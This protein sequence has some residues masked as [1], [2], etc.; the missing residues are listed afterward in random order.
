MWDNLIAMALQLLVAGVSFCVGKFLLP[1]LPKDTAAVI[2]NKMDLVITYADQYVN[3]ADRFMEGSSGTEKLN[4]VVGQLKEVANRYGFQASDQELT[5]IAQTAFEKMSLEWDT[6]E[7][8]NKDIA[9]A[10]VS[11]LKN[12]AP[13]NTIPCAP[14]P[15][16]PVVPVNVIDQETINDANSA[17]Q[18][19]LEALEQAK[20]TIADLRAQQAM[21]QQPIVQEIV[22]QAVPNAKQIISNNIANLRNATKS[23]MHTIAAEPQEEIASE[24]EPDMKDPFS[25]PDEEMPDIPVQDE[26]VTPLTRTPTSLRELAASQAQ[27]GM[28]VINA[29]ARNT[30]RDDLNKYIHG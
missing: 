22:E 12:S 18:E 5:A 14:V 23:M 11:A 13:A 4:S 3:W 8:G 24:I 7:N 6:I 28:Q 10:V 25:I 27:Q 16:A 21:T 15:V 20:A 30:P 19:A 2:Q 1:R 26:D 17:L 9:S 29:A